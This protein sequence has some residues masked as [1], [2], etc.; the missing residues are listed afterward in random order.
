MSDTLKLLRYNTGTDKKVL[1]QFKDSFSAVIFNA[2]IVAYS[3]SAVSD[4]VAVHKNQYIIDPQTHI[5]QQDIKDV[6]TTNKTGSV[7]IKR[8][9]EL[10]LNELP[11]E[12]KKMFLSNGGKLSPSDIFD[13]IDDL[14]ECVYSF[15]TS[16]VNQYIKN[17]EYDKYL[18]YAKIGPSPAV[19]I[20]PYFMI[21]RT[22]SDESINEWLN[23]NKQC[24][25]KFLEINNNKY[26]TGVQIVMDRGILEN[27][28]LITKIAEAYSNMNVEYAF[29]WIDEFNSFEG[30]LIEQENF[31]QLLQCLSHYSIK[32]IMA[33]GGYDAIMLCNNDLPYRIH[34]V[35]QSVGYG[36][37]RPVTPVGGGLPVNK[38]Y[39]LPFHK[40][41]KLSEVTSLLNQN[42]FFSMDKKEASI[43][44]YN[45]ICSCKQCQSIIKHNI[46]N[47]LK[48]NESSDYTMRNGIK[49]N[50]PT[51][52]AMYIAAVHFMYAKISEWTSI[53]TKAFIE[54]K[55]EL[56]T[57]YEKYGCKPS[58]C[59]M[60]W[61]KVYDE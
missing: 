37:T 48:Y 56:I 57:E 49:R 38:Y 34:G 1:I 44:F 45:Q 41:L 24:A 21:K 50:R 40:R 46:D 31:K 5:Y 10:Y 51:N 25:H 33:Y 15:T 18:K 53:E 11:L 26:H 47:F 2:T 36:E 16:Y 32:P 23:L 59:L 60:N 58:D 14:V 27:K 7:K 39:F 13:H 54:L 8:S 61:C 43:K 22:Y 30:S 3:K 9:V 28:D 55:N 4:L 17:K 6:Q 12:L 42:G 29:I 19:A 52:D 35:A 20:A